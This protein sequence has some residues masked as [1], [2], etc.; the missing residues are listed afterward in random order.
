[1]SEKTRRQTLPSQ[2]MFDFV[3]MFNQIVV[4]D[5][6][7]ARLLPEDE[8]ELKFDESGG[9]YVNDKPLG[10]NVRERYNALHSK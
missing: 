6:E 2:Q 9:I 5:E 1:M 4:L 8:F 3:K 10:V 7:L